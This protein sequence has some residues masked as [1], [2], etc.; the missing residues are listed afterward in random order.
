MKCFQRLTLLGAGFRFS[1]KYCIFENGF[2]QILHT[3]ASVDDLE[4]SSISRVLPLLQ[5][6]AFELH[7]KSYIMFVLKCIISKLLFTLYTYFALFIVQ[8][9]ETSV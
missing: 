2:A 9:M 7:S 5:N 8:D 1:L 6:K 4:Y 3:A